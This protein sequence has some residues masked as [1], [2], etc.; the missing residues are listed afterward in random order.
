MPTRPEALID[1]FGLLREKI[2]RIG[3]DPTPAVPARSHHR[4]G[5]LSMGMS[6]SAN[7]TLRR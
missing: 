2:I 3:G 4:W 6:I 7:K 5:G 1:G